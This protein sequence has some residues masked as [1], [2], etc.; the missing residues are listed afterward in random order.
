MEINGTHLDVVG[1]LITK[2]FSPKCVNGKSSS[3][4]HYFVR[5]ELTDLFL[6]ADA[7]DLIEG[8]RIYIRVASL[9]SVFFRYLSVFGD[10]ADLHPISVYHLFV[11]RIYHIVLSPVYT[12]AGVF[13]FGGKI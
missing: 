11:A 4:R 2:R 9:S 8:R 3:K 7:K 12:G 13:V 6:Y 5:Q 1:G 10:V